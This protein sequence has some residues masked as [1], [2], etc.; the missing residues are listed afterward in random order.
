MAF[1]K[2]AVARTALY[3]ALS[4]TSAKQLN[5]LE[6]KNKLEKKEHATVIK[7]LH[8]TTNTI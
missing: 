3:F 1:G 8:H 5:L 7:R 4:V 2:M 6:L